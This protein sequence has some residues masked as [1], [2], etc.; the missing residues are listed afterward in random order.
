MAAAIV[1]SDVNDVVKAEPFPTLDDESTFDRER[2]AAYFG[3]VAIASTTSFIGSWFALYSMLH[4]T[5]ELDTIRQISAL[6][7]TNNPPLLSTA[8][9]HAF[10]F[11]ISIY[12]VMLHIIGVQ[13]SITMLRKM[14]W[15]DLLTIAAM[16][17][18]AYM[19]LYKAIFAIVSPAIG[20]SIT[21]N[22]E[23]VM[24]N[25]VHLGANFKY[26]YILGTFYNGVLCVFLHLMKPNSFDPCDH[27]YA[28]RFIAAMLENKPIPAM[29]RPLRVKSNANKEDK[30]IIENYVVC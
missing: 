24:S 12:C 11:I 6:N 4:M 16:T 28:L 20:Q 26:V 8:K 2:H 30:D 29:I 9:F 21:T 25:G 23:H 22:L 27:P 14:G 15:K 18:V 1:S 7:Q 10:W 17:Y 3:V 19:I 5:A 13:E